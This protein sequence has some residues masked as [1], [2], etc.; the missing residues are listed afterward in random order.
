MHG[1][2]NDCQYVPFDKLKTDDAMARLSRCRPSSGFT[3]AHAEDRIIRDAHNM[4]ETN[5]RR[6]APLQLATT[7]GFVLRSRSGKCLGLTPE[8]KAALHE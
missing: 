5:F 8:A 6:R 2:W 7:I 1:L 3:P 4:G